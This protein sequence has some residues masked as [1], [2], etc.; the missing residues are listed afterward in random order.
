MRILQVAPPW[1]AVPP[2][3]YGGIE[4]VI[5]LLADGLVAAG[6]DVTLLASGGSQTSAR[7]WSVFDEPPSRALGSPAR[8]ITHW[9]RAYGSRNEFDVIHDHSS[10]VGAALAAVADGPPVVHTVH[11]PWES[12]IAAAYH[13]LPPGLH[14]VAISKDHARRAPSGLHV[15]VVHNG[16]DTVRLPFRAAPDA[17]GHLAFVGRAN[18]NKG[19]DT[20]IE[21]ARRVGRRLRMALKINEPD[22]CS[23]F[24]D[25]IR[26]LLARA[27][28]DLV[29]NGSA[30]QAEEVLAGAAVSVVP[31]AW[32][33]PFGLVLAESLACG[34]PV[35]AFA[36]GAAAEIVD[37]GVTGVLVAPG[38]VAGLCAGVETATGMSRKACRER[39]DRRFSAEHMV[40]RYD[41]LYQR[42][43]R[44]DMS[45]VRRRATRVLSTLRG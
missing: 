44:Q 15:D 26:P 32:D 27:D 34:T 6:H 11:G 7:L 20:A 35:A 40:A 9:M 43:V 39:M 41:A 30:G 16:V 23:Y 13:A 14:I 38:D 31:L 10:I 21:V 37:D 29:V 33:E 3:G 24:D 18:P 2:V 22:E 5:A 36:R 12:P 4:R 25:V 8:E 19:P 42:V 1:F 17:D 28:V 45:S